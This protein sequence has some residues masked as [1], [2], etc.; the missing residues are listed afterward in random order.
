[1]TRTSAPA[2]HH[3]WTFFR[4][5]GLDQVQLAT[6]EDLLALGELDQKLWVALSCPVKGLELD[7]K[8]LAL[9]DADGDGHIHVREV[10]AAVQWAAAHLR[11]PADLLTPTAALPLEAI[12]ELTP[13]GRTVLASAKHI[14][15]S[16]GKKDADLITVEDT[17]DTAKILAGRAPNGDG[18]ITLR[19]TTDA[20][21]Q[22]L[23]KEIIATVGGVADRA[24]GDGVNADKVE[25]FFKE[26]KAYIDFVDATAENNVPELGDRTGAAAIALR[27]VHPKVEDYFA[28]CR[29][30]AFDVRATA[31][32]NRP[33]TEYLELAA[34]DLTITA[35]E[36]AK[37]PLARIESSRPLPLE[38]GINPA[39]SARLATFRSAVVEPLFGAEKKSLTDAEWSGVAAKFARYEAWLGSTPPSPIA[40][41]GPARARELLTGPMRG[42]LA[43]LIAQD[44]SLEPEYK[45][46]SSVDRLA[47]Y[48]RDLR[49]LLH[50]FVNFADFYSPDRF[51][52]FQAGMLFLDSRSCE[53][54]VRVTDVNAHAALATMSKAY[55]AY[56][57]CRRGTETM[58]VAACFTQGDSDY[59][60]V[61]RN[62]LFYDRQHRDW[63]ATIMKIVDNPI[64]VRQAF[65]LPYKKFLRMIEEQ[66][67][68]RAAT[69]EATTGSKLQVTT[70]AVTSL[71]AAAAPAPAAAP[72]TPPATQPRKLDVGTIA[73]LG[74]GLGALATAFGMV[75]GKFVELPAWQIP[76]VIFGIILLISV[77]SMAIA[78][79][80][81]RQRTLGPLL[82]ANGWAINGRVKVNVPFGAALTERALL[83][84]NSRRTIGDPYEDK[85]A[86]RNRRWL[87][88]V[89]VLFAAA[90]VTA[91]ILHTWPFKTTTV[92][93][94]EAPAAAPAAPAK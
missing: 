70:T 64:S 4:T 79:M 28:R 93:E 38:E 55:I 17:A 89:V 71:D 58:K 51:A 13:E 29:L 31:A 15:E 80:K 37:F 94:P 48:C 61:G 22:E 56:L 18:V 75:F 35:D 57:D 40:K 59:L 19:A 6:A 85:A 67:T 1:M 8:T 23:I 46:I 54:C 50:N 26:V 47:R 34:R 10:V 16:L 74:V 39:W 72:A 73:A 63:D 27:A 21:T 77:P 14:L 60:F 90:L 52:I 32:L 81:I 53:M 3:V 25:T 66:V 78:W 92:S 83:P 36:V 43:Y 44:K 45:A 9:V 24:G 76:I 42:G 5:G 86:R 2:T 12:N 65:W 20:E 30:A 7:E 41:L 33:E 62:G 68:K 91:R 84:K 11:R 82:E 69:A 88:L 87:I 49:S